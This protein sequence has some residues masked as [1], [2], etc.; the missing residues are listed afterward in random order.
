M[1][2]K[3]GKNKLGDILKSVAATGVAAAS[4]GGEAMKGF[5][6]DAKTAKTDIMAS[7]K[8]EVKNFL[9][10]IDIRNEIDRV[11]EDYDMEVQAKISFKKKPKN[12]E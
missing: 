4:I 1:S 10:R 11:L 3:D 6:E 9:E 2:E 8:G 5:V 7:L 12:K